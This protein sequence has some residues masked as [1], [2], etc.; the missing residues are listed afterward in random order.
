MNVVF[1]AVGKDIVK[2][3]PA[4]FTY[5][6]EDGSVLFSPWVSYPNQRIWNENNLL[7]KVDSYKPSHAPCYPPD[8]D[9]MESYIEARAG[10]HLLFFG[11]QMYIQKYLMTPISQ[12]DIDEAVDFFAL[13]GEPFDKEMWQHIFDTYNGFIPVVISAIPEGTVVPNRNIIAKISCTDKKCFSVASYL[14]TSFLRGVWYPSSTGTISYD[15]RVEIKKYMELTADSLEGLNFKLHSFAGRGVSSSESAALGDA[16][17]MATGAM[18]SDTVE[19]VIRANNAYGCT[20]G[21]SAFSIPATEHSTITS[22]GK[23]NEAAAYKNFLDKYLLPGKICA[24]VS[25][26]YDIM[27]ACDIWGTIHKDQIV[28]SGGTLVVRPDSGEP[29]PTV[30]AV[31]ERLEKYF[32]TTVNS[33]GYK[34]LP[35]CIRVIQGDGINRNA[36]VEILQLLMWKGYSADNVAFGMGGALLQHVNRD[37]FGFVMKCCAIR[38]GGV[39]VDVFKEAPGKNSKKGR[40]EL[41]QYPDRTYE[42]IRVEDIRWV[43]NKMEGKKVLE[44][45]YQLVKQGNFYYPVYRHQDLDDVRERANR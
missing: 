25:D 32:G 9:A 27:E 43:D 14:E 41:I 36:I 5:K 19:G 17:H 3:F 39:W 12:A 45:A 1:N 8:A 37:T 23:E 35:D 6:T 18:G 40:L 31:V 21:M 7:L 15:C 11:L 30:L 13:H 2:A 29:A 28:N 24:C 44:I 10:D 16:G 20:G 26:S 22:W 38:I 33:K 34:V 42:T 4:G